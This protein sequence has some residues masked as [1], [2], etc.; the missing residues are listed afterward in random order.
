MAFSSPTI[1][2]IAINCAFSLVN[3]V[4]CW[5]F[6]RWRRQCRTQR[7]LLNA[8]EQTAQDALATATATLNIPR[9]TSKTWRSQLYQLQLYVH[10]LRQVLQLLGLLQQWS[11][12][13]G[14][15]EVEPR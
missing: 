11:R 1:A 8:F 9:L 5:Q 15:L 10:Y 14:I 7:R 13:L 6:W 2:V 4:L 3:L 12:K